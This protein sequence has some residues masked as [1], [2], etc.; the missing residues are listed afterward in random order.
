MINIRCFVGRTNVNLPGL[1][2]ILTDTGLGGRTISEHFRDWSDISGRGPAINLTLDKSRPDSAAWTGNEVGPYDLNEVLE[3]LRGTSGS[4]PEENTIGLILANRFRGQGKVFGVM[5]DLDP[6]VL[7]GGE[8]YSEL[9]RQGCAVFLQALREAHEAEDDSFREHT[10]FTAIHELGHVFN[11]WHVENPVS[12]MSQSGDVSFPAS[13]PEKVYT[14]IPKHR[15]FLAR[16][17]F[18]P[19]VQPGGSDFGD[20]GF[21]EFNGNDSPFDKRRVS[22]GLEMKINIE[23]REFWRFEP[24]ELD[25]TLRLSGRRR[26]FLE[27]PREVDPAY[28]RFCIWIT[29]PSGA[30][31]KYR[32]VLRCCENGDII[33]ITPEAPYRRDITLFRESGDYTFRSAGPH[34]LEAT[35]IVSKQQIRS[36]SVEVFIRPERL[37]DRVCQTI[38]PILTGQRVVSLLQH[39]SEVIDSDLLR[40]ADEVVKRYGKTLSAAGLQY[41]LGRVLLRQAFED[42]HAEASATLMR[43]ALERLRRA[44][45][46][47][48]LSEHRRHLAERLVAEHG[49][50]G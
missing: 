29:E 44:C 13:I 39:R 20:R 32:P 16:C 36:N 50:R 26:K 11:L 6:Y 8:S 48:S 9:Q 14:F 19:H 15:E 41:S 5:F 46:H 31:R 49:G 45:D 33:R 43:K 2:V 35:L 18:D 22:T 4:S 28:E 37:S 34:H 17:E 24:V 10:L 42:G 3:R 21:G 40:T 12:F 47:K 1:D 25:V 7:G 30:R 27:I 23:P 38:S